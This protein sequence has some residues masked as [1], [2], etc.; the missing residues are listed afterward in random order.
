MWL[1]EQND[2]FRFA[3]FDGESI[4]N[5]NISSPSRHRHAHII[6]TIRVIGVLY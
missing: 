3:T 6:N 2:V 4:Q 5:Q 1:Q